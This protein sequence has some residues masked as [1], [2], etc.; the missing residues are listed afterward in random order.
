MAVAPGSNVKASGNPGA[1][2]LSIDSERTAVLIMDYQNDIVSMVPEQARKPLL[3]RAGVI[4]KAAREAN[5]Q[6]IYPD[7]PG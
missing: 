7:G 4:L 5:L 6:I 1:K 3:A 2:E